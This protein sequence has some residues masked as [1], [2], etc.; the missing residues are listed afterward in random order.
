[1]NAFASMQAIHTELK[2]GNSVAARKNL[3]WHDA[4]FY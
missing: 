3:P 4:E 2:K 1:M